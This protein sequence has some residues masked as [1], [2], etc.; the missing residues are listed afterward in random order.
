MITDRTIKKSLPLVLKSIN[1]S[2]L[3]NKQSGKVR[4]FY[5]LKDTRLTITTD[6]QSA[7]D[8]N[9]GYIPFKGAVLNQLAAFWFEKTKHIISNHMIFIPHPN[10]LVSRNC[11]PIPVEMVVRGYISG[12]TKTSIWYSYQQGERIIYGQKFPDNLKKNQKLPRPVITP[13]THG[14]GNEGHDDRLTREEII[15]NKLVPEKLYLEME[16]IALSLFDYG[17]K[18]CL[19][20]GLILVDTK[21]EFGLYKDK[22]MLMDEIHTPDSSRFWISKTYK[23]RFVKGLEP[24]NFDKEFLRLWYVNREYRG[25]GPPPPMPMSLIVQLAKRYISV[26]EKITDKKFKGYLYPINSAITKKIFSLPQFQAVSNSS[27]NYSKTGVNYN[28]L[29]PI[30]RLAQKAGKLT[31]IDKKFPEVSASRGESAYVWKEKDIYRAMVME[32]LGTKNLIADEVRKYTKKTHYDVIAQ[33]TVAMIVND[34]IV[35]GAKPEV[36]TAYF[37]VGESNWFSD[38]VR[39]K[40][41]ISGW[42][43]AC[44]QAG[45]VW[46]GGETP[47]LTDIIDKSSIDLA[48]SAIGVIRPA[49]RLT[50]GKKLKVGDRILLIGSSGVHSNGLTLCRALAKKLP[51]GYKTKLKNGKTF[52]EALLTPTYIY[53]NVVQAL[54]ASECEIHYMTNITGHGWRKL[55]R[56]TGSFH[57]ILE[58][59]PPIAPIFEFIQEKA[60]LGHE[61][62]YGT[63]NMG[64]GFAIFVPKKDSQKAQNIIRKYGFEVWDGGYVAKGE[65]QISILPLGITFLEASLKLRAQESN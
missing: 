14:G 47:T 12:V 6:R 5:I 44:K 15:K 11:E 23:Q 26:Y 59:I 65:K 39:S 50:L 30:K 56:A 29:D 8:V 20:K 19:K 63:F 21:Y 35:V 32:G 48:G 9:L 2:N 33:D 36:I 17:S 1:L 55:M 42:S 24:E 52:G 7:F 31:L 22:L 62:M 37:A 4:D 64:A 25:D 38:R 40:D 46:G 10:V 61:E 27:L 57:Y 13:T 34:L 60:M 51:Q 28:Y 45:V 53:S 16:K 43:Q 18:W 58:L 3:L 41:L 54:Y 49:E